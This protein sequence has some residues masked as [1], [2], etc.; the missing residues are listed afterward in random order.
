MNNRWMHK[1]ARLICL[2]LIAVLAGITWIVREG[3][4]RGVEFSRQTWDRRRFLMFEVPLLRWQVGPVVYT[5]LSDDLV[6][7]LRNAPWWPGGSPPSDDYMVM[8]ACRGGQSW[9]RDTEMVSEFLGADG[10]SPWLHWSRRHPQRARSL[11]PAVF[12][13]VQ[14]G[15][16]D[17]VPELFQA[18]L[19]P[20]SHEEFTVQLQGI[21]SEQRM[22]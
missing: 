11:W 16:Y 21:I 15:H 14:A 19:R 4:V 6:S 17:A 7:Y 5:P 12:Q 10:P 1:S 13:V 3:T 9:A 22:R 20:S 8:T 2:L 18:A